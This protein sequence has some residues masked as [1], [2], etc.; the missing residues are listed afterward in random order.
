MIS[1]MSMI[2]KLLNNFMYKHAMIICIYKHINL[3]IEVG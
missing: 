2:M 1:Y 3:S